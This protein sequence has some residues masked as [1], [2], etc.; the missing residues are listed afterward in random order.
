M[1]RL[2]IISDS[3]T[4]KMGVR[5]RTIKPELRVGPVSLTFILISL[6]CIL[7]LFYLIQSNQAATKGYEIRK[8][9]EQQTQLLEETEKL[10]LQSA[11]L[12]SLKAIEGGTE[13]LRMV[14]TK[15]VNYWS[16]TSVASK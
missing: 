2:L 16:N 8:L 10:K 4:M 12:Q 7:S 5:K 15:K 11:Q 3:N 6:L 9:E 1:G 14:P 13:E